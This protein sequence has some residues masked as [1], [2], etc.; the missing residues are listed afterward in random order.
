MK[1]LP[2][3]P[4]ALKADLV[5]LFQTELSELES[6]INGP[7]VITST[8]FVIQCGGIYI[9]P[10][11]KDR[12]TTGKT[13]WHVN[14]LR[15]TRFCRE[16]AEMLAKNLHNGQGQPGVAIGIYQAV[17]ARRVEVLSMLET[18]S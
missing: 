5:N 15:A 7:S 4:V 13:Q 6:D 11:I 9:S 3:D 18:L 10:E 2:S 17:R 8:P 12:K 1:A 16:D 14:P